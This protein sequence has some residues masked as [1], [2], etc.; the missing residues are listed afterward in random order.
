MI[1]WALGPMK[2]IRSLSWCS[3]L[4]L[5]GRYS[6]LRDFAR[7][8]L[9]SGCGQVDR[10]QLADLAGPT[11]GKPLEADH[12]GYDLG[13]GGE[14]GIDH[15]VV[16]RRDGRGFPCRRAPLLQPFHGSQGVLDV[17]ADQFFGRSP[18]E[19]LGDDRHQLVDVLAGVAGVDEC[20]PDGLEGFGAELV[21]R[22][23]AV[24]FGQGSVEGQMD[25]VKPTAGR[26][27]LLAVV[28][29]AEFPVGGGQFQDGVGGFRLGV[30]GGGAAAAGLAASS[31]IFRL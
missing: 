31:A 13:Q 18:L 15:N 10:P 8:A 14:R 6:R 27:V 25:V 28:A 26:A 3:V 5:A 1:A 29:L 7:L 21:G 16:D 9:R 2:M 22:G 30:D 4:W 11:A 19:A 24:E 17:G 20:L 12:I 23:G